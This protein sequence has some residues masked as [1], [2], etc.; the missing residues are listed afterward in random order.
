MQTKPRLTQIHPQRAAHDHRPRWIA[1]LVSAPLVCG[2]AAVIGQ[3]AAPEGEVVR[4]V[5]NSHGRRDPF[6]QL[7][8]PTPTPKPA[9][10]PTPYLDDGSAVELVYHA[11]YAVSTRVPP[12]KFSLGAIIFSAQRS[13]VVVDD[14]VFAE[15][16]TVPLD[17]GTSLVIEKIEP[18]QVRCLYF[19]ESF[20]VE[21]PRAHR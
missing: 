3:P 10:S 5:Y 2:V 18:Q 1:L 19:D 21:L 9:A 13:L 17:D 12:P 7:I 11:E 16:D 15:G 8:I 6:V 4:F 14:Q 20:I